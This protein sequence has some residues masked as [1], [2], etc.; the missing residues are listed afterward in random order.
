M[1]S[2]I[3]FIPMDRRQALARGADLPDQARGTALFADISGFTTLTEALSKMLGQRRGAEE[4]SRQLNLVYD[5]LINEV[6]RYGGSVINF[7]GDAIT[8]WF[9][10]DEGARATA[11]ALMM[12]RAMAQFSSLQLPSGGMVTLAMKAAVAGGSTR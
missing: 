8:C 3:A 2:P 11:S 6:E 12:Q 7:A 1:D 4:I 9:E 10:G 5:A